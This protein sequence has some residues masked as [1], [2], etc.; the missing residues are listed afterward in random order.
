[1]PKKLTK[2]EFITKAIEVHG[3]IYDYSSV[4]YTGNSKKVLITCK[5]HGPFEKSP[6][7]HL[8]GQGCRICKGYVALTK[9][10]FTE[11]SLLVHGTNYN[12]E[13]VVIKSKNDKVSIN[14]PHHGFFEQ[15]PLNHISGQG[16]P[17]CAQYSRS[18]S[19]RY[20]Q[21]QF[22][23]T[24]KK[25]HGEKYDYS[26]L[27]YINSQSKVKISCPIHGLFTMK[28]NSHYNGQGCPKCGRQIANEKLKLNFSEFLIRAINIHG[29]KYIYDDKSYIN[30]TAKFNIICK[31][32][33]V[34]R[35]TPHSHISMK[36]G[37]PNCGVISSAKSSEKGWDLVLDLFKT[38]HGSRYFYD[39]NSYVNVTSKMKIKCEDHGW[40]W[41]KPNL[42]YS[43]SGCKKCGNLET[44]EKSKIN[45]KTFLER[46]KSIHGERYKY[47]QNSWV[48]IFSPMLISC[49]KH[50]DFIQNPRNHYRGSGCPK[51][52][53]SRG[54]SIIRQYLTEKGI[55]FIE[56][57]IFDGLIHKSPLK[58]DFFIPSI[59][60]VIEY[61][62]IQHYEPI[63]VFGG[64]KGYLLT[65]S[66]DNLKYEFLAKRDIKLL[67]I[68]YDSPNII[69]D[70]D[71]IFMS[72]M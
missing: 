10:T 53:S 47:D 54:E 4:V 68:K 31:D 22:I 27:E 35:Q 39:Q 63:E 69:D 52:N 3:D 64:E 59:N 12:Y 7:H 67:I 46:S 70:L 55:N 9:E 8:R 6:S 17:K 34:F 65:V 45:F 32:H 60:T 43:G 57:K 38:V 18:V 14:C 26:E 58:C 40:F 72:E 28:A 41:Q 62:G 25:I 48:D 29:N 49:I 2:E 30:Y 23:K 1:M 36:A 50:G 15:L 19:Q 44:A 16:C 5:K 13:N 66:R 51:C 11:R 21:E 20:S 33:G 61:N 24:V 37:C 56:Q 42:H 71:K